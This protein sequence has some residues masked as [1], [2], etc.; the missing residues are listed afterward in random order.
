M[1]ISQYSKKE[2]LLNFIYMFMISLLI[3]MISSHN[4]FLHPPENCK[5]TSNY[6]HC[7]CMMTNSFLSS[8]DNAIFSYMWNFF[9]YDN[10]SMQVT[11]VASLKLWPISNEISS[12][13]IVYEDK[14][15]MNKF[16]VQ[17]IYKAIYLSECVCD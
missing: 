16:L 3:C 4:W 15:I 2:S 14:N 5:S 6:F 8:V 11:L 17:P 13:C 10:S 1:C 9:L 7:S 12:L